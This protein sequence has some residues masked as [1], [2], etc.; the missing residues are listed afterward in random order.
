MGKFK[1]GLRCKIRVNSV[2]IDV[3]TDINYSCNYMQVFFKY[4]YNV[5]TCMHTISAFNQINNINVST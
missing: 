1:G 4:K 2:I 5:K 3:I